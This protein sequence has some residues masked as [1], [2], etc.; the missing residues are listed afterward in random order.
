MLC[1]ANGK[2]LRQISARRSVKR[3]VTPH[4]CS[5]GVER[6]EGDPPLATPARGVP[7]GGDS[8]EFIETIYACAARRA[9]NFVK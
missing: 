3:L 2:S 1:Y 4:T 9:P 6:L 7:V 5:R 8:N